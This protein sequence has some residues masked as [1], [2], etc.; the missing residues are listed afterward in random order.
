MR[1]RMIVA[2]VAAAVVAAPLIL[3][4]AAGASVT[5]YGGDFVDLYRD[6]NGP[7]DGATY[8]FNPTADFQDRM[9][10][11][12]AHM[13]TAE[14]VNTI[15]FYNLV[16]MTDA[17]RNALFDDLESNHQKAV[18]RIENYD[19]STFD[20]DNND[21]THADANSVIS[22]YNSDDRTHGYTALLS[23]LIRTGRLADIAYFAVNMPVDDGTVTSH[24]P[25]GRNNPAWATSQVAYADYLIGRL[26]EI[27]GGRAKL[28]LSVFYGWDYSYN[29][30]SYANVA[31]P[32]DGYF[33][34]NYSYPASTPPDETA[35]P[36]VLI[37]Q[38]RLQIGMD[39]F[40][41]QYPTQPVVVEYGFHT[42]EYNRGGMPGQT[43]GLVATLA[44]KTLALKDTTAYYRNLGVRGSMYF[45]Q[46]L[47]KEEGSPPSIDDWTLDYPN[48]GAVEAEDGNTVQYYDNGRVTANPSTADS[49]ASGGRA[50]TLDGR[51]AIDF[52]D[53][54]QASVVRLRS[55]S[56]GG[57]T[58][59]VSVNGAAAQ[60]LRLAPSANWTTATFDL[61]VPLQGSIRLTHAPGDAGVTVD[62][63]SVQ[64]YYEAES[65][66]GANARV[67]RDALASGGLGVT[68]SGPGSRVDFARG[69]KPGTR[70]LLRYA[71]STDSAV[72]VAV[73]GQKPRTVTLPATGGTSTY[74]DRTVAV[75][76]PAG[77]AVRVALAGPSPF[78]LDYVGVDG[79]YEAESTGGLYNGGHAVAARI[80]SGGAY[81]TGFDVVGASDVF[82]E[83]G[84]ATTLTFGYSATR[85]ASL[86]LIINGA[87]YPVGFPATHGRFA[88]V[89]VPVTI[90][91]ATTVIAQRNAGDQAI[92]LALDYLDAS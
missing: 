91:P 22:Y 52:I 10:F 47:Y 13:K 60:P 58:L 82:G 50:V 55:R 8:I 68:L 43:A 38:P 74:A 86:T 90:Q 39:R 29:T 31:H 71:A 40:K 20:F 45:A 89:S 6:P 36:S 79:R 30:P 92:G 25:G 11:D 32:A 35:G 69:M 85:D 84:P 56:N 17:D 15:G 18:V 76:V 57:A 81:A 66:T 51:K 70:L 28:Y 63:L 46:N 7:I 1:H 14:N 2:A 9:A 83:I 21:P 41:A 75:T 3:P 33:F 64:P 54:A 62:Q 12:F 53:M 44:A 73:T 37:N 67:Y 42:M 34:N 23:Y 72:T 87:T 26:R 88:R 16:Q 59:S 49:T 77:A 5:P 19:A 65:G 27:L 78:R 24:F 80:A 61:S 48:T 4:M